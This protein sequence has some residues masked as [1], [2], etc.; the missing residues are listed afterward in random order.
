MGLEELLNDILKANQKP[1]L[2]EPGEALFWDDPYISKSM[3]RAHLDPKHD[4]AS[5]KPETI[6]KTVEHL[7]TSG[8]I[9]PGF[10]ILDLGCGPGL[11]A[12]RFSRAGVAVV[13][14]DLSQR[15]LDYAA[16]QAQKSGLAIEYHCR[17]FLTMDYHQKFDAVLQVYGELNVFADQKRDLLL[18]KI[19]QAL[20]KDG[21]LIFD[22]T[23]RKL[24]AKAGLKNG[25]QVSSNGGF[26]RLGPNLVLEQG[27]D[28][29]EADVWL[30]QY[31]VIDEQGCS[32]YRNWFH[33]Y[34]RETIEAVLE[35]A[36]FTVVNW[37][38]DL[39]G[40][41]YSANGEWIALAARK[42]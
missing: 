36:G 14:L 27:F 17:D 15:S 42:K 28:Y 18:G 7:L 3:L 22:V 31:L 40:S 19:H 25:W 29:P 32:V 8:I 24:R 13:G 11:Y 10:E 34:S 20:K 26:W 38:G 39:T 1:P 21:L 2:F 23:T 30:D 9:K 12:E 35:R 41:E 16:Q 4:L 37:W 33:D 6:T 5:R